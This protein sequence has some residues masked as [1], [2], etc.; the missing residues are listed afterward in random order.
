MSQTRAVL[1]NDSASLCRPMSFRGIEKG[2]QKSRT[3][4]VR[5]GIETSAEK[6]VPQGCP[7]ECKTLKRGRLTVTFDSKTGPALRVSGSGSMMRMSATSAAIFNRAISVSEVME[8]RP[9]QHAAP[10]LVKV[11]ELQVQGIAVKLRLTL[12]WTIEPFCLHTEEEA[13]E[14]SSSSERRLSCHSLIPMQH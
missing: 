10:V 6:A 5:S 7:T 4:P 2:I 3:I 14:S 12:F 1:L 8:K 11:G 13:P 9:L